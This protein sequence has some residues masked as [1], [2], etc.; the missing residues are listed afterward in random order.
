MRC[1]QGL[2]RKR[3]IADG[4]GLPDPSPA[5]TKL[6]R[7][8]LLLRHANKSVAKVVTPSGDGPAKT[9]LSRVSL[10]LRRANKSVAKVVTPSGV[11]PA[12][13]KLSR[14][15]LPLRRTNKSVAKVVTPS[16]DG[17]APSDRG[18]SAVWVPREEPERSGDRFRLASLAGF[19]VAL[20]F[21]SAGFGSAWDL[22]D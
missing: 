18:P 20:S 1:S 21:A 4:P 9:K 8:S 11:G 22:R 12:K 19:A 15:S 13:T 14:V 6:S 16:G 17:P 2:V 3:K 5:R 7:F 10:P